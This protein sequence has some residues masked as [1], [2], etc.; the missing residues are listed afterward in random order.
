VT[1]RLVISTFIL[2]GF[3]AV[4]ASS[5]FAACEGS[6]GRGW[7]SGKGD[8]KYEMAGSDKTC[9]IGYPNFIDDATKTRVPATEVTL[10][11]APKSG[12]IGLTAKGLVYTPAAGFKGSDK[13][14]TKNTAK[15]H[16]GTLSG[17]ITVTVR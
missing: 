6:G 17:C 11:R 13:F 10:T 3:L 2:G 12:K 9:L 7:A 1:Q 8:G 14:C 15:G 5:A 4:S 16:K